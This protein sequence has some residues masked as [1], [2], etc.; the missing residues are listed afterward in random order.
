MRG[1]LAPLFLAALCGLSSPALAADKAAVERQFHGWLEKDLWPKAQ[2]EGVPRRVFDAAFAGVRLNWKLPDL[3]QP[4]EKPPKQRR[5]TQAEFSTPAPYFK[6]DR[7]AQ[8]AAKGRALNAGNADLLARIEKTYG[9][10]GRIVLALW[11]RETGYGA[12]SG[13]Y[14]AFE[15]L[16]TKAFMSTRKDLFETELLAALRIVAKGDVSP[17]SMKSSWAGAMGQPQFMP[18]SFLVYAVDFDG[19]G[20]RDIW[21]SVP[22]ALASIANYLAQKGWQRGRDWGFEAQIPDTVSCAQ[23]G[24]DLARPI[25]DWARTGITRVSGRPFPA[26]ELRS[27]GMMLVPAGRFGPEFIVTPNFYVLKAYN[28]SD[29]YAL[30][31][32]NLADR[33]AYGSGA[34]QGR[35]GNVGH[36]LRS[37]VQAMQEALVRLG[38][39][40]GK[41]DGLAG[42]KTR[43]SIG[44]WQE[45]HG[46][47]STCFPSKDLRIR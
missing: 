45:A 34:F 33:I 7:L 36:M 13:S 14:S 35:W 37:D 3:V 9:V 39:D 16:G 30:Y 24:P 29:L 47:A 43:R 41:V 23:E 22:D 10:P 1:W 19:D 31:V 21:N 27:D 28:N 11:G 42:Y 46:M 5:Q 25:A 38:H 17:G 4:G 18:S 44:R 8:T 20:R 32:G 6:E 40:V 26:E 2:D 15:V 12:V